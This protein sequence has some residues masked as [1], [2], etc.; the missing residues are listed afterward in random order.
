MGHV[1]LVQ[2]YQNEGKDPIEGIYTFPGSTRAAVHHS[3]VTIGD[4][5][6]ESKIQK[7]E[8]AARQYADALTQGKTASLLNQLRPADVTLLYFKGAFGAL[9]M[10]GFG[11]TSI[12]LA[13][14][15]TT[16]P[17][18]RRGWAIASIVC[19][20]LAI[21]SFALRSLVDVRTQGVECPVKYRPGPVKYRPG[22]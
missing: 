9:V 20:L 12:I 13:L 22:V 16:G 3:T 15:A 11:V 19:A 1:T 6:I 17:T 5:V 10:I 4:E 7:R 8:D 14:V 18:R 2:V 21:G